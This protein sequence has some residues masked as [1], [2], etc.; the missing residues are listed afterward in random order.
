MQVPSLPSIVAHHRQSLTRHKS[1]SP[2]FLI[3]LRF[4][5]LKS[6]YVTKALNHLPFSPFFGWEIILG[7]NLQTQS[8]HCSSASRTAVGQ[9]GMVANYYDGI[10]L[11]ILWA[12]SY[13]QQSFATVCLVQYT[14]VPANHRRPKHTV[15]WSSSWLRAA[16]A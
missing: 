14:A 8:C 6:I 2:T 15:Q 7:Y 9:R 16:R 12:T 1:P 3:A 10:I 11:M 13:S 4:R 5:A